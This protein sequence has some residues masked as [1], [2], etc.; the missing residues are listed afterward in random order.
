MTKKKIVCGSKIQNK[1]WGL[2]NIVGKGWGPDYYFFSYYQKE[3]W[4][5]LLFSISLYAISLN[6]VSF[7]N[8]KELFRPFININ[9]ISTV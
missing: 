7:K 2:S 4:M 1:K 9:S 8:K 3:L 6:K 5:K